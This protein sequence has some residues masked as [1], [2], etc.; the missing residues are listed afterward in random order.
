VLKGVQLVS[1]GSAFSHREPL[2][3]EPTDEYTQKAIADCCESQ[4]LEPPDDADETETIA[5]ITAEVHR[6]ADRAH[7]LDGHPLLWKARLAL[8]RTGQLQ[9]F[10]RTLNEVLAPVVVDADADLPYPLIRYAAPPVVDL[11]DAEGPETGDELQALVRK[12]GDEERTE[13]IARGRQGIGRP[14]STPGERRQAPPGGW[15]DYWQNASEADQRAHASAADRQL[16]QQGE[17][18]RS[19]VA[20]AAA[21]HAGAGR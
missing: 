17:S 9:D 5:G 1:W 16:D 3:G 13:R 19:R 12:L 6:A 20:K 15:I 10:A 21:R 2:Y 14:P 11:T 7:S 4:G 8:E 18:H